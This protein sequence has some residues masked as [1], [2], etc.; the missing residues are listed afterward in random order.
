[1][2]GVVKINSDRPC[3]RG[4]APRLAWAGQNTLGWVGNGTIP[5]QNVEARH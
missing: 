4:V 3:H 1:M 2:M 5:D